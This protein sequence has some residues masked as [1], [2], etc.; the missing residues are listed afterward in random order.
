MQTDPRLQSVIRIANPDPNGKALVAGTWRGPQAGVLHSV[1]RETVNTTEAML[2]DA[3]DVRQNRNYGPNEAGRR[4]RETAAAPLAKLN[5]AVQKFQKEKAII[6]QQVRALNPVRPYSEAGH[7]A[8]QFDLRLVDAFNNMSHP[9]RAALLRELREA[10]AVRLEMAEAL[11]RVPAEISGITEQLRAELR[12]G[13]CRMFKAAE[14]EALDDR[15]GQLRVAERALRLSVE[16]ARSVTG[17]S[18]IAAS[19]QDLLDFSLTGEDPVSWLPPEARQ[20]INFT[21]AVSPVAPAESAPAPEP[22]AE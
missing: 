20:P 19:A 14:F 22:A 5:V 15:I 4:L 10:P 21:P 16:A 6:R 13:L 18:D 12:L 2:R 7:W 1:M 17:L 8:P 9:K 3:A 11:L